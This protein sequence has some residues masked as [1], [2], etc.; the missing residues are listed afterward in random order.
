MQCQTIVR[1]RLDDIRGGHSGCRLCGHRRG[2]DARRVQ[3]TV[4]ILEMRAAGLDPLGPYRNANAPAYPGRNHQPWRGQCTKCREI[5]FPTLNNV[6]GGNGGCR[7]C[8]RHGFSFTDPATVYIIT[9]PAHE[10]HKI[11]IAGALSN[12]LQVHFSFG[13]EEFVSVHLP[14]GAFAYEAEQRVLGLLR[15][16]N[17]E[18]PAL[19]R[20]QM[21]QGGHTETVSAAS[22]SLPDILQLLHRAIEEL[23]SD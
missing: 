18:I 16:R 19:V 3:E 8:A 14:T 23:R 5:V 11:G 6:M 15:A 10:A 4:A 2:A 21:P 17:L 9:H 1:P 7:Y 12:R 20:S 13:W 22:V